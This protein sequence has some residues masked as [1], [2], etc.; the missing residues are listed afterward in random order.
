MFHA[1]PYDVRLLNYLKDHTAINIE[2][3]IIDR[4]NKTKRKVLAE[5]K[6]N[7]TSSGA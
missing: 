5:V 4:A 3:A 2:L 7:I 1:A 6:K